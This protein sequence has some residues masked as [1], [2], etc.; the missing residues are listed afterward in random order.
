V[1]PTSNKDYNIYVIIAASVA[2][3]ACL[4]VMGIFTLRKIFGG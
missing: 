3:L 2:G 4:A 1:T